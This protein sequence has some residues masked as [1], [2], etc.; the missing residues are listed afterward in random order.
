[1]EVQVS[2]VLPTPEDHLAYAKNIKTHIQ[3]ILIKRLPCLKFLQECVV[4]HIPHPH[5]KE[6]NMKADKVNKL[7]CVL[8]KCTILYYVL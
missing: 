5:Q 2:D 7:A 3:R 4:H 8:D 6:M 1:M